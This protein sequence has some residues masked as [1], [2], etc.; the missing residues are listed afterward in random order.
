MTGE[1]PI[2]PAMTQ[3]AKVP[4]TYFSDILCVWAFIAQLRVEE[5]KARF[6]GDVAFA[7]RFCSVFGDTAHKIASQWG[8]RGGYKRFNA[9][10]VEAAKAFPEVQLDHRV[11]L[12][13]R[14]ASS[15]GPHVFLKA[16]QLAEHAGRLEA[17]AAERAIWAMRRAFFQEARDIGRWEVQ[18]EVGRGAGVE[19]A[20]V[21]PLLRDGPAFAALAADYHAAAAMGVVGSPSFVLND[22]RQKLYGNVGYRVIEANIQELI[23]QPHPDQASW[24]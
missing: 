1:A 21:E 12:T 6:A 4:I 8:G 13:A 20:A 9:H 15:T 23:R 7:F 17:G 14:P 3:D 5:A 16:V 11:W 2:W 22:G 19:L 10:V 18:C 24:C